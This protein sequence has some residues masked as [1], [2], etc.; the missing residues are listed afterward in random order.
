MLA[1]IQFPGEIAANKGTIIFIQQNTLKI[2]ISVMLGIR[3][4]KKTRCQ[5]VGK[6][7]VV[8]NNPS[9]FYLIRRLK[10]EWINSVMKIP[11]FS[12]IAR[13]STNAFI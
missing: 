10:S 7:C 3:I 11:S 12:S 5:A 2:K 13:R 6:A 9:R 1:C 8:S 4:K